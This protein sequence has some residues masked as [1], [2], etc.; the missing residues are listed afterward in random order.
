MRER[1]RERERAYIAVTSE[2]IVHLQTSKKVLHKQTITELPSQPLSLL[3]LLN[4]PGR[5]SRAGRYGVLEELRKVRYELEK[6]GLGSGG[7]EG[8][9]TGNDT[10]GPGSPRDLR[11]RQ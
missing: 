8:K 10:N 11:S 1:E 6:K 4:H 3:S 7:I 5:R 2:R 9:K